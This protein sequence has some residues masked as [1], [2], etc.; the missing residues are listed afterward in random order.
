MKRCLTIIAIT[1]LTLG[2]EKSNS[3]ISNNI[4]NISTTSFTATINNVSE[5][6]INVTPAEGSSELK[7][8]DCIDVGINDN[9]TL[10]DVEKNS[11]DIDEFNEGQSVIIKY[12]GSIRESYPAQI[13][14]LEIILG[15]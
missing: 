10:F 11:C 8:S 3:N 2:C 12:D 7:S 4:D 14:A 6:Y 9:T 15:D 13:D 5:K 1:L